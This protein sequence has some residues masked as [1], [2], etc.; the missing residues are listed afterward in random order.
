MYIVSSFQELGRKYGITKAAVAC[1]VFDGVHRGH[2]KIT[3]NLLRIASAEDALPV[4]LTFSPHPRSVVA[5]EKAPSLL[6]TQEQKLDLLAQDG[7]EAAV[8]IDFTPEKAV[9][10]PKSFVER[11]LLPERPRLVGICVGAGWRFGAGGSGDTA[12][13]ES[14]GGEKGF[15]VFKVPELIWYGKPISSTRIRGKI[16]RG[17]MSAANRMLG[18]AY[19]VRGRVVRGRGLG[20]S[21]F[22]CPTANIRPEKVLYPASGVYAARI[23]V[24][25]SAP[26]SRRI[27]HPGIAYVGNAP[28]VVK[29]EMTQD[30][31]IE[32]HIFDYD[33]NLYDHDI[34]VEFVQFLHRDRKFADHADLNTRI[35]QDIE[36]ARELLADPP[37]Q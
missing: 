29:G 36:T 18:R 4:V 8:I 9:L 11:F 6:T 28:S 23:A 3:D 5:P 2:R 20:F 16:E 7:I 26:A 24:D 27:R 34:E 33:Q 31:H 19:T 1:G 12:L 22:E 13:L 37:K 30:I 35:K 25:A 10:Q 17:E 32:C 14:I 15:P 21:K